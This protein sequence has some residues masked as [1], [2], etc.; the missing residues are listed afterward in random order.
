MPIMYGV[1][2]GVLAALGTIRF[3]FGDRITPTVCVV[4]IVYNAAHLYAL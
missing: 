1:T 4:M 3:I 2:I